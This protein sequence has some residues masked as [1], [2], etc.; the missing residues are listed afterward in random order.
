MGCGWGFAAAG[1]NSPA[2]AEGPPV[3]LPVGFPPM[4]LPGLPLAPPVGRMPRIS[5]PPVRPNLATVSD[6]GLAAP[7]VSRPFTRMAIPTERLE[8]AEEEAIPVA[9]MRLDMIGDRGGDDMAMLAADP[10]Q[11]LEPELML[12]S[13]APALQRV[14]ISP[15]HGLRGS[16]RELGHGR[17]A[18]RRFPLRAA[19]RYRFAVRRAL[20][21][22]PARPDPAARW[23]GLTADEKRPRPPAIV[24]GAD[25][26]Q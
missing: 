2:A 14:P 15:G 8:R 25:A 20:A 4:P 7:R 18:S 21:D 16:E 10:A 19:V 11:G 1:S 12:R 22:L 23:R 3:R 24:G 6:L 13:L 9:V 5:W 26:I 17:S